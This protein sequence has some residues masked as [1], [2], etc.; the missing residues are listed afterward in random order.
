MGHEYVQH[1][2]RVEIQTREKLVSVPQV[3]KVPQ[4]VQVPQVQQVERVVEVP[5]VTIQEIN[6]TVPR[7]ETTTMQR[8][9]YST[10][11]SY[12]AP[13]YHSYSASMMQPVAYNSMYY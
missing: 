2:P 4:I 1:V 8:P 7:Y 6:R 11:Q 9:V 5:K 3:Q 10:P 13:S 12:I